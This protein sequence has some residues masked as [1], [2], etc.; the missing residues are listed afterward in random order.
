MKNFIGLALIA[1]SLTGCATSI[2]NKGGM[3][4]IYTDTKDSF[5]ATGAQG[6]RTGKACQQN[7]LGAVVTGDASVEAAKK[8]GGIRTVSSID[9]EF[10]SILGVYGKYCTIVTGN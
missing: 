10:N 5:L 4:G 2:W 1:V 8:E 9:N 7:I 6:A 3:G